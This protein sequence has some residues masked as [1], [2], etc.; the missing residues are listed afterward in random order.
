MTAAV[1]STESKDRW[2]MGKMQTGF[3]VAEKRLNRNIF[4]ESRFVLVKASTGPNIQ[5]VCSKMSV[6]IGRR[7]IRTIDIQ[8]QMCLI[9]H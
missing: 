8:R 6:L 9:M 2:F 7:V 1:F 3:H 4:R 5:E